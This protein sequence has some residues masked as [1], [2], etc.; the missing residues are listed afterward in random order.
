[1]TKADK[2][3]EQANDLDRKAEISFERSDTDG[4]LSQW[5][6]RINADLKRTLADIAD[7]DG[8]WAFRCLMDGKEQRRID[9]KLIQ[10]QYGLVWLLSDEEAKKYGRRFVPFVG[11]G[12]GT[13]RIQKRMNLHED[14]EQAPA[15]ARLAG[16]GGTGLSGCTSVHVRV[17]RTDGK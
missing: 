10:G 1:M 3:R 2:L 14:W 4:F 11:V 9:A 16:S 5:A 7:N 6:H 8:T 12:D 13:S 15:H 17:Y